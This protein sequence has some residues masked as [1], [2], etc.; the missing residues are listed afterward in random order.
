MNIK[1][2]IPSRLL[3]VIASM[4]FVVAGAWEAQCRSLV[5]R[6]HINDEI[7]SSTWQHTRRALEEATA[8]NA[9]IFL[10]HLNTYGGEVGA[11]DSMRTALLHAPM[12]VV[13]FVDNNAASAGAL[14]ALACDSVFMRPDASMGAATVVSGADG[15]AMPD[16][17]QSYMRA[18]MRATAESHGKVPGPDSTMVWRRNPLIAEAMVDTRVTVP[19]LIDSTR[20]LTLTADEAVRWHYAEG[21]A[22]TID[23]VLA[24]LG[25]T[26]YDI[27][28]FRPSW[29]DWLMGFLTN[30]AVQGM[31]IMVIVA[32]IYFELQSPGMGFPSMAAIIAALLYFMPMY[33]TGIVDSW[34]VIVFFAGAVLLCLEVFVIPGFG[35]AGIMGIAAMIV[36]VIAGLLENFALPSGGEIDLGVIW[37]AMLTFCCALALA[38][39]AIALLMSKYGSRLVGRR[40]ELTHQQ[41]VA[42]GYIGVDTAPSRLVGRE[43]VAATALRPSGKVEVDGEHYDA[44]ALGG[45]IEAG[46]RVRITKF[47]N[48]QLYVR[49]D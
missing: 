26:D 31:L 28:T 43:G 46:S 36:A 20:V 44:V 19:G 27:A 4:L 23:D 47:E 29:V 1:K 9:D 7:G 37:R 2:R 33:L 15:T 34:V 16:K 3:A 11:A 22:E 42:D 38:V 25:I 12:P 5:Y 10:L 8:R 18:I 40:T 32:G 30:P 21:K 35:V 14:I 48:A 17:Y 39:G 6:L 13:A 24:G 49:G 41:R 45:F